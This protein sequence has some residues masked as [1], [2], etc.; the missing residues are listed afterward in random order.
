MKN[1]AAVDREKLSVIPQKGACGESENG[2]GA[3]TGQNSGIFPNANWQDLVNLAWDA[4]RVE[5][6]STVILKFEVYYIMTGQSKYTKENFHPLVLP[7][8]DKCSM[9]CF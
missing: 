3:R 2:G 7:P 8:D 5:K 4:N 6:G 1:M 9:P